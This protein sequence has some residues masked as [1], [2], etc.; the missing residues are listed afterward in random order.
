MYRVD[1][2]E[3][4]D[5]RWPYLGKLVDCGAACVV[6]NVGDLRGV[7]VRFDLPVALEYIARAVVLRDD[8]AVDHDL[9]GVA[10]IATSDDRVHVLET[11]QCVSF[12]ET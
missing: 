12:L 10:L 11:D 3:N 8:V 1:L 7:L 2:Q 5:S 9:A 4:P 6:C